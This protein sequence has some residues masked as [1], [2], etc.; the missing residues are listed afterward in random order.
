MTE[1]VRKAILA[2]SQAKTTLHELQEQDSPDTAALETAKTEYRETEEALRTA[3]VADEEE[4]E[5]P[6]TVDSEYREKMRIRERANLGA[7]IAHGVESTLPDGAEAEFSA[8]FGLKPGYAPLAILEP[9]Q[10]ELREMYEQTE[11][12]ADTGVP[13]TDAQG[14]A[15]RPSRPCSSGAR[16]PLSA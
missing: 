6:V 2:N 7:Y 5:Q 15:R 14:A 16:L 10:T 4:D 1:E 3:V 13:S 9:S 11:Y 8:A 12:R